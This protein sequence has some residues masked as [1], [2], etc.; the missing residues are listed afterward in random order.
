MH[1]H[2]HVPDVAAHQP[3][4]R[5]REVQAV[6]P[7]DVDEEHVE[8]V[9][10][11]ARDPAVQE[12]DEP[13]ARAALV[14]LRRSQRAQRQRRRGAEHEEDRPQHRQGH[15]LE[16]VQ[17][18]GHLRVHR[19]AGVGAPDD[20][21]EAGEPGRGAQPRPAVA[22][23]DE[24]HHAGDVQGA[25]DQRGGQEQRIEVEAERDACGGGCRR[26]GEAQQALAVG[27]QQHLDPR[28]WARRQRDAQARRRSP[29]PAARARRCGRTRLR[30]RCG[31][32]CR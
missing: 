16:H 30:A 21:R 11:Q 6:E 27:R 14:A 32:G 23:A 15:V 10:E 1:L 19:D 24:S 7:D 4:E 13:L 8:R 22:A 20:D 31:R 29:S 9:G 12:P 3:A 2:E 25:G 5:R 28:R 26:V 18:D 17:A